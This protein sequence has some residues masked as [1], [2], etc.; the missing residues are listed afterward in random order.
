M[1]WEAIEELTAEHK[2]KTSQAMQDM[3]ALDDT[4]LDSVAGG[5]YYIKEIRKPNEGLLSTNTPGKYVVIK[6]EGCKYDLTDYSCF[7]RD[8]CVRLSA[9]YFGCDK[10][11]RRELWECKGNDIV[12]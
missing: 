10:K 3:Q 2:A 11:Y 7:A 1:F 8:A 12:G 6:G 4:D 5:V 9:I